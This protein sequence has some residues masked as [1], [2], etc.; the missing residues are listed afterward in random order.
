M[1]I[2]SSTLETIFTNVKHVYSNMSVDLLK[3]IPR[4]PYI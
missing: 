3:R 1:E 4:L 2:A